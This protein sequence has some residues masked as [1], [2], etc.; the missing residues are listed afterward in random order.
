MTYESSPASVYFFANSPEIDF[1]DPI[2]YLTDGIISTNT[3]IKPLLERALKL[4]RPLLVVG[5]DVQGEAL[6]TMV[7]NNVRGVVRCC[8][9]RGF[10]YGNARRANIDDL[11]RIL[12]CTAVDAKQTPGRGDAE[13]VFAWVDESVCGSVHVTSKTTTFSGL[14]LQEAQKRDIQA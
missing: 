1:T 5:A 7:L 8:A 2:I 14:R 11:R 6:N 10:G 9:V 3:Q 12:G 4:N 13:P